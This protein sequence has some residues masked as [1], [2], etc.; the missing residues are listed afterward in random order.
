MSLLSLFFVAL[1]AVLASA[2]WSDVFVSYWINATPTRICAID[3]PTVCYYIP[4]TNLTAGRDTLVVATYRSGAYV[5]SLDPLSPDYVML[6]YITHSSSAPWAV[7]NITRPGLLY[8]TTG[9]FNVIR[10]GGIVE[11]SASYTACG[12]TYTNAYYVSTPGLYNITPFRPPHYLLDVRTCTAY[13]I[14]AMGG[15]ILNTTLT[16]FS[17]YVATMLPNTTRILYNPS[18][19]AHVLNGTA[20][21]YLT[22]FRWFPHP[23]GWGYYVAGQHA[24][25]TLAV[26]YYG[27]IASY[28]F[29]GPVAF[30]AL[31]N[32]R[33][34]SGSPV[35]MIIHYT[36]G[37]YPGDGFMI[38]MLWGTSARPPAR[39]TYVANGSAGYFYIPHPIAK[40]GTGYA[41]YHRR[42]DVVEV[43]L[44]DR[45]YLYNTRGIACPIATRTVGWGLNRL[46][47]VYEIE[48]C[49]N[50][51][52]T[53]YAALIPIL[54]P[55][56]A[57]PEFIPGYVKYMY[58]DVIPPGDCRRL[59]WDFNLTSKPMLHVYTSVQNLC[60]GTGHIISTT[61]Y[62]INWRHFLFQNNT[63]RAVAPIMPDY[64]YASTWLQLIDQMQQRYNEIINMLIQTLK[65]Q[66]N[67]T[68]AL[69]S[70][71]ASAPKFI[72]T[73]R[74][75]SATSTWLR[76]TL[77]E[78]QRWQ[79]A[80]ASGSFSSIAL[81]AVPV[82]VAPAA[83]AA[84]AVAWAASRRDDDVATTAAVAGIALALF[85]ILMTLIYGTGSLALVALG[86]IVAAA[87]AAWR[88]IT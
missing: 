52:G 27:H 10:N 32:Y 58:G 14:S 70:Y 36:I 75:E 39:L 50:R 67:A 17:L 88:R 45:Y 35:N 29:R 83:A 59:R 12:Q 71:M 72:G 65:A 77:N 2:Q 63:L 54:Q 18:V 22:Y 3:R 43:A 81:P 74:M 73:I 4:K 66:A 68:Q 46:D 85:G 37:Q 13:R 51:T 60:A 26:P 49:N 61:G 40:V 48:I 44:S 21:M 30:D 64:D 80:G 5:Y 19:Y 42:Y 28:S 55:G 6:N 15:S 78:L 7:V 41:T 79:V 9:S 1:L 25:P 33:Q 86:V 84:V 24:V 31:H 8:T 47:R 53:V 62:N 69:Q 76:T 23:N 57:G 82:A 16:W 11:R 34:P 20:H 38:S 56:Y 87:A